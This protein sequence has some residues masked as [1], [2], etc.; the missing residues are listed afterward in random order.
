VSLHPGA[1]PTSIVVEWRAQIR[2]RDVAC[3]WGGD[4]FVGD[5]EVVD[6]LARLVGRP[7]RASNLEEA[8]GLIGCALIDAEELPVIDVQEQP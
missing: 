2:G 5:E 8:R 3:R 4:Q 7:P 6:R 1:A